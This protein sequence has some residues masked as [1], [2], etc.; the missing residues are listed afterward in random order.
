ML[1][2]SGIVILFGLLAITPS[3]AQLTVLFA[4]KSKSAAGGGTP[5]TPCSGAMTGQLD[6]SNPC[7]TIYYHQVMI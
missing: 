7:N 5:L 2:I 3:S 4:G 6:F 1:R